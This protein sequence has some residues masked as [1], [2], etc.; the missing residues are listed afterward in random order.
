MS[1]CA[2]ALALL[3][4][5]QSSGLSRD[6]R[7]VLYPTAAS[8]AAEGG[9]WRVPIRFCVYEPEADDALRNVA[10]APLRTLLE[11]RHGTPEAQR[12]AER[13]R[14][15]LVDHER[16]ERV[17]LAI[18]DLRFELGPTGP[19]GRHEA[20]LD[21]PA[22]VAA[23]LARGGRLPL[24]IGDA[25]DPTGDRGDAWLVAAEGV[26]VVSD[27]DDTIKVTGVGDKSAVLANTFLREF[28]AV[29]GMPALLARAAGRGAAFHYVSLGPWQLGPLLEE[30]LARDGFPG[31]S[32]HLQPFRVK[33]GEFGDLIGDSREKKLAAIEPL[34]ATWPRRRFV[35][36]GD[37]SQVD[38]EVYGELA[39]RHPGRIERIVIR[40][41]AHGDARA[42][43]AAK[44]RYAAAFAGLDRAT[45]IVFAD[46]AGVELL[47]R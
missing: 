9:G 20:T 26:S 46:P 1:R 7:V 24:S 17:N 27:I 47:A 40:D 4:L 2:I 8:P 43:A 38:P 18:G 6:E 22:E 39:R 44:E 19:D 37:S 33:D 42:E 10:L 29:P 30:F 15:F 31:G 36:L 21:V 28:V 11:V 16:G 25:D 14:L 41:P 13:A 45:C 32:L 23:K 34:L 3:A 12:F 5:A 35:L